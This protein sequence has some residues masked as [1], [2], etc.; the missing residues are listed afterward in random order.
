M[1]KSTSDEEF[2]LAMKLGKT[3]VWKKGTYGETVKL[4]EAIGW[5]SVHRLAHV[6]INTSGDG[7]K[8]EPRIGDL[9]KCPKDT[10]NCP[11]LMGDWDK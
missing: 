10:S 4:A 5:N 2:E 3:D 9:I 8:E 1:S 11:G 7:E 6:V